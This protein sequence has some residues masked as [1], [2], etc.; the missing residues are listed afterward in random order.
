MKMAEEH[1]KKNCPH[2]CM[3]LLH[4]G[5]LAFKVAWFAWISVA[6]WRMA[7]EMGL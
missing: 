1:D 6:V 4:V 7:K 2:G 3:V 5:W